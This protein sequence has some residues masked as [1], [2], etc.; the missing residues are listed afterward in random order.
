[1]YL[2]LMHRCVQALK[3][4]WKAMV[5]AEVSGGGTKRSSLKGIVLCSAVTPLSYTCITVSKGVLGKERRGRAMSLSDS[6]VSNF[7]RY[8]V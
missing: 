7:V 6:E 5:A 2:S 8:G 4:R 3:S 1:M